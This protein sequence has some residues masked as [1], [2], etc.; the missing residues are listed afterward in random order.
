MRHVHKK[1]VGQS[2]DN[3]VEEHTF[4]STD[5]KAVFLETDMN[6]EEWKHKKKLPSKTGNPHHN[7]GKRAK[8]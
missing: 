4:M 2:R 6:K 5:H 7:G 3:R 8:T 1:S